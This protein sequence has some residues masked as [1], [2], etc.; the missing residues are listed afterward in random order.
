MITGISVLR[1]YRELR[2][3][4]RI[5]TILARHGLKELVFLVRGRRPWG[6]VSSAPPNRGARLRGALEE[7][8]PT[9]VK[10]GQI[11]SLRPDLVPPDI[12]FELRKLQDSAPPVP[13][14][15]I[16]RLVE[17]ELG[18]PLTAVFASFSPEPI[19]A[20]SLAQVHR[21][22]T[23]DGET[24][25]VK[26]QRPGIP[27]VIAA[28][29]GIMFHLARLMER[30][31]PDGELYAPVATV[32]EFARNIRKELD[33]IHEAR[34]AE[35]FARNFA[36]D[37]TIK[38]PRVV[39][40]YTSSRVLTMEY[41]AGIK[42]SDPAALAR[43]GLD[44]RVLAWNGAK[45]T[46]TQVFDHGF[47]HADPHPGNLLALPGN[48]IAPLDFGMMGRLEGQLRDRVGDLL[49]GVVERDA[50][51]IIRALAAMGCMQPTSDTEQL[52]RDLLDLTD[53]YYG[54]PLKRLDFRRLFE[55]GIDLFHRHRLKVPAGLVLMGKALVTAEG[56]GR[57]LDPDFDM[58]TLARPYV[59][60]LIVRRYAD[61]FRVRH[62][63]PVVE[64][65]RRLVE[66][67]PDA[68][69]AALDR[70]AAKQEQTTTANGLR[71]WERISFAVIV[72]TLY[73]GSA[74]AM[75][76]NIGP[77]IGPATVIGIIGF[78]LAVVL[79]GW[80]IV[81]HRRRN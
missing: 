54:V 70:L 43:A 60:R 6:R 9:F 50:D 59:R 68:I 20:A 35:I 39:W 15:E 37:G 40:D 81:A 28:D 10:L 80:Y 44:R 13:F 3:L 49:F 33:F 4:R 47:F 66:T 38:V 72:G 31:L 14:A 25:A 23:R 29:L 63:L 65:Y 57:M 71:V 56:V 41:I 73:I 32:E 1:R 77:R 30:H 45:A 26:V 7:L 62:W 48:V 27:G 19:A 58:I 64:R 12:A 61:L 74:L 42:I 8:G 52:R 69:E 79:T 16:K 17:A 75:R 36:N 18:R 24:V 78:S 21:A 2:R 67:L 51:L 76:A 55:E 53:E 46:L 22:R 5:T 34:N 11:L